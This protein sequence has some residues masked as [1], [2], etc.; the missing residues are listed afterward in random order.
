MG[1]KDDWGMLNTNNKEGQRDWN[2]GVMIES[3]ISKPNL[4][5]K[6]LT[7]KQQ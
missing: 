3:L 5:I 2:I 4:V 7:K 6:P 1:E